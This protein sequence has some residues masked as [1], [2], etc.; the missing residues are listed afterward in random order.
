MNLPSPFSEKFKMGA[1]FVS[2]V[3][4][5]ISSHQHWV[6]KNSINIKE[7][8]MYQNKKNRERKVTRFSFF[9]LKLLSIVIWIQAFCNVLEYPKSKSK[10]SNPHF[11]SLNFFQIRPID[12]QSL[13]RLICFF[14]YPSLFLL[15][16]SWTWPETKTKMGSKNWKK[17][18][19][20]TGEFMRSEKYLK[21]NNCL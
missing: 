3:F 9:I 17:I 10:H 2:H 15:G 6:Q 8:G 20:V 1:N 14:V 19:H 4:A 12:I 21:E 7:A 16:I 11:G 18:K 5:I 13:S